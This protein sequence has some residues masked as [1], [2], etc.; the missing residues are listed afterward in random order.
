MRG[1]GC[2]D[3]VA[4]RIGELR[5][6]PLGTT[7]IWTSALAFSGAMPSAAV[8]AGSISTRIR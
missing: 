8:H 3:V 4:R 1:P 6:D 7:V 5:N 2:P